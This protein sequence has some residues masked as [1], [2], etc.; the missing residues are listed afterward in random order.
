MKARHIIIIAI[1]VLVNGVIFA[2]LDFGGEEE[3]KEAKPTF[4]PTVNGTVIQNGEETFKIVGYGS[5]SSYNSVDISCEVQGKLSQGK[6][7]LKPGVTLEKVTYY[8]VYAIRKPAIIYAPKKVVS[9][10]S[11]RTSY[12]I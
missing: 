12:P 6:H 5:V 2:S 11:L 1:F 4:V 8:L 10:I 7:H 9:S 3:E